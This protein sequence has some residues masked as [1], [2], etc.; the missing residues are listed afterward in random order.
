[1]KLQFSTSP[2]S[3]ASSDYIAL[4]VF[5]NASNEA[6]KDVLKDEA[7]NNFLKN[8]PKFGKLYETQALFTKDKKYLLVGVGKKEEVNFGKLQ[9]FAGTVAKSLLTK[10]NSLSL[11]LPRLD[12]LNAE[13]VG[14]AVS[15]GI[16]LASYNPAAEFKSEKEKVTLTSVQLVV[17][18]AE[19]GYQEGLKKGVILAES[20]N[21]SRKLADLPANIMTPT[22]FLDEV[23][24][25]AKELKL[26]ATVLAEAQAKRKGMGA[27]IAV[28]AGSDIPS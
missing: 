12:S 10:A 24:K 18:K 6:F 17:E 26:K 4:P 1:M 15:I 23:K 21:S 19:R 5:E 7:I 28:A 14:E 25:V 22:Y 3:T 27:F 16:E 9:N 8:N 11:L 20:I 13:K 2:I